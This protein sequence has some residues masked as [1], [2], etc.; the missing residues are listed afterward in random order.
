MHIGALVSIVRADVNDLGRVDVLV[1]L[2][3]AK[4]V[5]DGARYFGSNLRKEV[6][7]RVARVDEELHRASRVEVKLQVC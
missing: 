2:G 1:L 3:K 7:K 4:H 6:C 5:D